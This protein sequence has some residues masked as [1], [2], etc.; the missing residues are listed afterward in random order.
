MENKDRYFDALSK[1]NGSM[2]EIDIGEKLGL[3]DVET[4]AI[5]AQLLSEHKIDF[6]VH[7][8]CNYRVSKKMKRKGSR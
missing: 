2:N 4:H 7:G 8:A 1:G 6:T 5:I 3:D